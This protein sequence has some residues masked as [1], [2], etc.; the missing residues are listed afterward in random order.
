MT[1]LANTFKAIAAVAIVAASL[2]AAQAMTADNTASANPT[3]FTGAPAWVK[4]AFAG[5]E[6]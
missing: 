3:G 6:R 1:N 5:K 2:T 4:R